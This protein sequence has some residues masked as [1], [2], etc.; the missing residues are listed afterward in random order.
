MPPKLGQIVETILYTSSLS[1]S[2]SWYTDIL[3]I[4]PFLETS[5]FAGFDLP[6]NTVLLIFDRSTTTADKVSA[7]GIIPKHGSPTGL[8]QH[9]SFA[10]NSKEELQEWENHFEEKGVEIVGRVNWQLGGRSIYVRD[11]E[12]H[13]IEL[14]TRG[15]WPVY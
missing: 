9:I 3:C 14:M 1:T 8:G 6:N 13:A 15:V 12:G 4:T 11:P 10:C 7:N 5:A 2:V